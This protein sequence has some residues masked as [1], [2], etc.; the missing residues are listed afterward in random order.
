MKGPLM[1]SIRKTLHVETIFIA[2]AESYEYLR[3]N[4]PTL[5]KANLL[6]SGNVFSIIKHYTYRYIQQI[7]YKKIYYNNR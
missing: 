1:H 4:I 3:L 5:I 2:I 6:H 7:N